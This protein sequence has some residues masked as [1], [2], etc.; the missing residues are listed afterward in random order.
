MNKSGFVKNLIFLLALVCLWIF[1]HLY[2]STEID[3]MKNKERNLQLDL[4]AQSD[5][6][7]RLIERE[8][9]PAMA[10]YRIVK[11]AS[12][13]LG[14]VRSLKPFDKITIDDNRIKQIK[15]IVDREYD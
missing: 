7:E 11:F 5:K 9:K 13:S 4:K 14:L 6:V 8:F 2:L 1:P 12:D 15:R 10:E 3:M